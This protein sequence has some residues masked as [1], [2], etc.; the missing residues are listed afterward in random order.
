MTNQL[1]SETTSLADQ[2]PNF[3]YM[4]SA[5]SLLLTEIVSRRATCVRSGI[6]DFSFFQCRRSFLLPLTLS[7][8]S[9][10]QGFSIPSR[11]KP[12]QLSPPCLDTAA[13]LTLTECR[14]T[15][16][17]PVRLPLQNVTACNIRHCPPSGVLQVHI[18]LATVLS[19]HTAMPHQIRGKYS[20]MSKSAGSRQHQSFNAHHL[21]MLAGAF[22]LFAGQD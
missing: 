6:T 4:H 9:P 19:S 11:R 15:S 13:D 2:H 18:L 16:P 12:R 22:C 10:T 1:T 3:Y 17:T 14:W 5:L 21:N 7:A 20:S 8:R